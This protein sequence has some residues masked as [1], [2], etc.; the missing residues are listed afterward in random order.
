MNESE[1]TRETATPRWAK[2]LL[3]FLPVKAQF[4][5]S[6]N[7]RDYYPF[8]RAESAATDLPASAP[9][10]Y[11]PLP[12]PGYVTEVLH[13]AGYELFLSYNPVDGF[14]VIVPRGE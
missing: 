2:D 5:L 12:L 13:L 9:T 11:L 3:R 1:F 6:G 7:I 10:N 8:P 14:S 4:I